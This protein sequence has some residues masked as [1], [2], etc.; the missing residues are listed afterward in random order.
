M[1]RGKGDGEYVSPV[2]PSGIQLQNW[3]VYFAQNLFCFS[4]KINN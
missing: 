1:I 2:H 4:D 3:N